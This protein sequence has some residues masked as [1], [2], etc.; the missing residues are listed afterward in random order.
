MWEKICK[1]EG[2]VGNQVSERRAIMLARKRN[3]ISR[4][5]VYRRR[6]R[7]SDADREAYVNARWFVQVNFAAIIRTAQ[8]VCVAFVVGVVVGV[9]GL[10]LL[11]ESG[12]S[13]VRVVGVTFVVWGV[14]C[15][16]AAIMLGRSW[17]SMPVH[18]SWVS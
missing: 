5:L 4:E 6:V 15:A 9:L 12:S 16:V 18:P 8:V 3:A 13:F 14:G 10:F 1:K 17:L 2:G 7:E 11:P